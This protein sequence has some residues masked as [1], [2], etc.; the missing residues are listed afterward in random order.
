MISPT[1][2]KAIK[3]LLFRVDGATAFA[4]L[5][6]A[7]QPDLPATL[8]HYHP[9]C[10]C[11]LRGVLEPDLAAAAPYLVALESEVPFTD[12]VLSLWGQSRAIFGVS[13]RDLHALNRHFRR[14]FMIEY[15]D[16]EVYFRYY[17][18]TVLRNYLPTCTGM[19]L[20]AF[21]G[22]V[23]CFIVEDGDP[24]EAL[25][26]RLAGGVLWQRAMV[27]KN[28]DQVLSIEGAVERSQREP[29]GGDGKLT[30]RP[31]QLKQLGMS[32][33]LERMRLYLNEVF[34]ESRKVPRAALE[35]TI[36]EL[37]ERAAGY[38][39]VL[40]NHVA[41]FLAAAWILGVDFD[42]A[43]PGAQEVLL[44]YEMDCG[45]KAEWLWDFIDAT[46]ASVEAG[47]SGAEP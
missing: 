14:Y 38:K 31:E 18:P 26:F 21:F 7:A 40:E 46:A 23:E 22:D 45:R 8:A 43:Y 42:E 35:R 47:D 17:D 28:S 13:H 10:H 44:D 9:E 11:L 34:P 2:L 30:V 33:Y 15:E 29:R 37:T 1:E 6:G 39:L 5:D 25:L 20:I 12:W 24:G 27:L 16:R 4:I 41:A 32:I 19:E 3:R 36:N